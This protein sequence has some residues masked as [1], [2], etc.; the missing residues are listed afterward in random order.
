MEDC[1]YIQK[2]KGGMPYTAASHD[3]VT[4]K[5]RASCLKHGLDIYPARM[6]PNYMNGLC[7]CTMDVRIVNTDDPKDFIEIPSFGMG[8]DK[9][10]KGP[11]KAMSYAYKYALLKAFNLATGD[12]NDPDMA[13]PPKNGFS[14][15]QKD[16]ILK[17]LISKA[18]SEL[19]TFDGDPH[20][21]EWSERD[22]NRAA[23][24]A[25]KVRS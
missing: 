3:D 22:W 25:R 9:Q 1:T 5:I 12:H 18:P 16:A 7:Y 2:K 8:I 19:G 4:A 17:V 24:I 6:E 21:G 11:G 13:P 14:E 23:D 10:D 15:T 20:K